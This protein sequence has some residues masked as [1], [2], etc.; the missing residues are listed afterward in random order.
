MSGGNGRRWRQGWAGCA[1][2]LAAGGAGYLVAVPLGLVAT[3]DRLSVQEIALAVA[4]L[5]G[6]AFAASPYAITDLSVGVGGVSARLAGYEARQR[7]VEA[8]IRALRLALTGVVTKYEWDH[9]RRLAGGEPVMVRFRRDRKLQLELERLDAMGFLRPLDPRGLVA[10]EQDH[11]DG[12]EEF[13]LRS[14][15]SV[16]EAGREYLAVREE[17]E[18]GSTTP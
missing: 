13:D 5:A 12:R 14:Y 18:A 8:D 10:I 11:G 6:V 16:T 1:V 3:G 4:L 2:L 15:V 7:A 17:L 9:L